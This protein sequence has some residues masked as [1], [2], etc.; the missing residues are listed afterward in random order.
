M[1]VPKVISGPGD[2]YGGAEWSLYAQD[3]RLEG[4]QALLQTL[5]VPKDAKRLQVGISGWAREA[6]LF[7]PKEWVFE[8]ATFTVD[9]ER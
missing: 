1:S 4:Y 6:G 8:T 7:G 9:V 3:K 2:G 5:L